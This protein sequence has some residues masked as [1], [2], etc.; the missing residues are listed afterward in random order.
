MAIIKCALCHKEMAEPTDQNDENA[1]SSNINQLSALL[2]NNNEEENPENLV[3]DESIQQNE[4]QKNEKSSE[5]ILNSNDAEC[6]PEQNVFATINDSMNLRVPRDKATSNN[7]ID[8]N[9]QK[10]PKNSKS[11]PETQRE[12]S[13]KKSIKNT[14]QHAVLSFLENRGSKKPFEPIVHIQ[15]PNQVYP[16]EDIQKAADIYLKSDKIGME[17]PM[18]V[19]EVVEEL[20]SRYIDLLGQNEYLAAQN[21]RDKM[22]V[23]RTQFR[24]KDAVLFVQQHLD[25]LIKRKATYE[26]KIKNIRS[27]WKNKYKELEDSCKD[28]VAILESKQQEQWAQMEH[29]WSDPARQRKYSKQ[30]K[31]LLLGRAA[32][33]Y[34]VLAGDL[35]GAE[36]MKKKN[37]QMEK[38]ETIES[39][40]EMAS[41]YENAR[42]RLTKE[43]EKQEEHLK[44]QQNFRKISL[45]SDELEDIAQMKKKIGILERMINEERDP[46]FKEKK[47]MHSKIA[48][49]SDLPML[50]RT[51][52]NISAKN[53]LFIKT[54]Q[55]QV[56]PLKLPPLKMA[57]MPKKKAKSSLSRP[58]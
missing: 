49:S 26:E 37:R 2:G 18:F 54:A 11:Q 32:E 42:V 3:Q 56:N 6:D 53:Q 45:K 5:E 1:L 34:M 38:L 8:Q 29:E 58:S 22:N 21:V 27:H 28:E 47:I 12:E 20:T 51:V 9:G 35:A 48:N 10:S 15:Q 4:D 17:D 33:R 30:S 23:L 14:E 57:P 52:K 16:P 13:K 55:L 44:E 7:Q 36:Q 43:F 46:A 31:N 50:Q 19:A 25:E 24:Q 40:N 41:D 39:Y